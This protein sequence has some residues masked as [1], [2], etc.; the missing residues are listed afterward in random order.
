MT[1]N[2]I[3]K[4]H[5]FESDG[6]RNF[7]EEEEDIVEIVKVENSYLL[8]HEAFGRGETTVFV[9]ILKD[10]DSL[11]EYLEEVFSYYD[12]EEE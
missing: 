3:L 7:R 2:A 1:F 11:D 6:I 4:K 8:R 9:K 5:S 10:L 12:E